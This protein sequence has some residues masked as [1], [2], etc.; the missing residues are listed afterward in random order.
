MLIKTT[1]LLLIFVFIESHTYSNSTNLIDPEKAWALKHPFAAFKV[2]KIKAQCDFIYNSTSLRQQ[3]DTFSNGGNLDAFR[4]V[5]FMLAFSQKV[6]V[7]ALRRLGKAHEKKNRQDFLKSKMMQLDHP[8]SLGTIMDLENNELA[9]KLSSS[10]FSDSYEQLKEFI[11]V[12]IKSGHAY[13]MKR[14]NK[15]NYLS[16]EN[17]VIDLNLY[18]RRWSIPKCL[19]PSNYRDKD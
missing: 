11:L 19:A 8:D 7:S 2:K 17:E 4:H 6:K 18:L 13:I 14:D 15:C 10:H 1:Y 16:C 9:F 3:L 12:E 5:F